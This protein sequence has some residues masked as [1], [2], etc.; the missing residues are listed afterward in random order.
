MSHGLEGFAGPPLWDEPGSEALE[1][2]SALV[3]AQRW[4]S[5]LPALSSALAQQPDDPALLCLLVRTLR[6]LGRSEQAVTAAQ[7]LLTVTPDDPYALRLATLVLLDVG[8]VDEAIGLA[9][10]AVSRDP[11]S[12]ANHL[13]LSRAWAQS[14]RPGAVDRQLG[15]ARDAVLLDPSSSDAQVQIG[16][17]LAA[18]AEPA[19]ARAAYLEALRLDPG[20]SAALNN[21]AVL[22]LQAGA[23]DAAARHLA[24]ALATDPHGAV[25]RR[26]LD[27]VSLRVLRRVGWWLLLAPVPALVAAALG[28]PVA[29][30][31]LAAIAVLGLPLL[32]SR[33]WSALTPGQRQHLRGLPGRVRWHTWLWPA[34]SAVLGSFALL[35]VVASGPAVPGP[36]L[37]G[38]LVVVAY[39]A[40]LRLVSAVLRPSWRAEMAARWDRVRRD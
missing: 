39:V 20:N 8:W 6:G 10:R 21:L 14:S 18:S 40:L 32:A 9:A 2:V 36:V 24:A 12:A 19:A 22:D 4:D 29:M 16:T 7:Q 30:W 31:A 13:A 34:T 28:A 3:A 11:S 26:N 23:P 15:S 27:A 5:A 38:Y 37:T 1:L 17:A 33:W 35:L 25:P